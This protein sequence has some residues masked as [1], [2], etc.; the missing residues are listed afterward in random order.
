MGTMI[1]ALCLLAGLLAGALG[2]WWVHRGEL[3]YLRSELTMAQDRL[4]GA[5]HA[6]AAIPPRP[7]EP[8]PP[9]EPL[10]I[11]LQEM[12]DEWES[13]ESRATMEAK[14]RGRMAQGWGVQAILRQAENEHP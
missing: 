8:E 2:T 1:P 6:K 7:T 5:W 14:I 3:A 12:V 9:P 10:P 11:D 13:P 4:L